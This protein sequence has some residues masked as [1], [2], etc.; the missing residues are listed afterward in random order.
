M[1]VYAYKCQDCEFIE[2]KKMRMSELDIPKT[3][4]CPECG[5]E[6]NRTTVL[7]TPKVVSGV[8]VSDKRPDGWRD[9]LKKVHKGAG[10][11]STVNT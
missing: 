4:P 1:P 10:R 8:S 9:V 11:T 2:E 5:S 7:G 3:E 6:T